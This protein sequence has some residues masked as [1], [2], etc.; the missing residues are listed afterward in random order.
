MIFQK[1]I[2]SGDLFINK[3]T[4]EIS[5]AAPPLDIDALNDDPV[6]V[7]LA[8]KNGWL[9]KELSPL[10]TNKSLEDRRAERSQF[11]LES[12]K[13]IKPKDNPGQAADL[14]Q[15]K[16]IIEGLFATIELLKKNIT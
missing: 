10:I 1:K 16:R 15:T 3:K 12:L 11:I 9:F 14:E 7:L 13:E 2:K 5:K 4:G 8:K 6:F